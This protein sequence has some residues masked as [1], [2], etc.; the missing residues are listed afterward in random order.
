[1]SSSEC[2]EVR[3]LLPEL[4]LS[5]LGGEERARA[6]QHLSQ[7]VDCRAEAHSLAEVAD[8][9][10][11]IAPRVEPPVGFESRVVER[12]AA[13]SSPPARRI[14]IAA[15]ALLV[16]AFVGAAVVYVAGARDREVAD[17]YRRTLAVADG[18][19]FSARSLRDDE[20]A[21]TG[22]VFGYQGSPSWIFCVIRGADGV[23]DV[24]LATRD[25]RVWI[26]GQMR[27]RGGEGSWGQ[28]LDVDL[29]DLARI[30]LIHRGTGRTLVAEWH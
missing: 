1:M 22:H 12:V 21:T 6:L 11:L 13:T 5:T 3:L 9:L 15:A 23:Y 27:V 28:A 19:Y 7:C 26:A 8:E 17:N 14:P 24:R 2:M 20:G 25:R 18:Q 29:H 30:T 16:A 10:L 4:A